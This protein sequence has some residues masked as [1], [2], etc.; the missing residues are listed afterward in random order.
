M[1]ALP[2]IRGHCDG[3]SAC[4]DSGTNDICGNKQNELFGRLPTQDFDAL[5]GIL[6]SKDADR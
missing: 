2:V 1:A 6:Q 3:V 5:M 4:S